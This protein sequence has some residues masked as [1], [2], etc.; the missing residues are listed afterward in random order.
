MLIMVFTH[1]FFVLCY[2]CRGVWAPGHPGCIKCR[3]TDRM[4]THSS[5]IW[6][7]RFA[8]DIISYWQLWMSGVNECTL[9][10]VNI[11]SQ[12]TGQLVSLCIS[13]GTLNGFRLPIMPFY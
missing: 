9:V 10:Q 4:H 6:W 2:R 5:A 8:G 1:I 12:G 13:S 7:V 11:V 3:A